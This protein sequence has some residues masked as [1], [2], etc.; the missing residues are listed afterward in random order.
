M[1]AAVVRMMENLSLPPIDADQ[2][3]A[4]HYDFRVYFRPDGDC[5][6]CVGD[7]CWDDDHRGFCGAGSIHYGANMIEKLAAL[8]LT[9]DRAFD[10]AN[11]VA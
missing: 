11:A 2:D 7:P 8:L 10:E 1:P 9:F 5:E 6:L 3:D 4:D